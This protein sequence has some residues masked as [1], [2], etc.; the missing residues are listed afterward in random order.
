MFIF[1]ALSDLIV[2]GPNNSC[3]SYASFFLTSGP[4][5]TEYAIGLEYIDTRFPGVIFRRSHFGSKC[6]AGVINDTIKK[7]RSYL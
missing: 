1:I 6:K 5:A 7:I 4:R 2:V 3:E